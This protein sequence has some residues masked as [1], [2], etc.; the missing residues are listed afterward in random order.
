MSLLPANITNSTGYTCTFTA[1][2]TYLDL[3][4]ASS[5]YISNVASGNFEAAGTWTGGSSYPMS[6]N[7]TTISMA[8]SPTITLTSA[9]DAVNSLT[10]SGS[11]TFTLAGGSNTL[12]VWNNGLT[13]GTGQIL[14]NNATMFAGSAGFVLNGGTLGGSG[15]YSSPVTMTGGTISGATFSSAASVSILS[16]TA[17]LSGGT[18]NGGMTIGSNGGSSN[19][20][21]NVTGTVTFGSG[22]SAYPALLGGNGTINFGGTSN[23]LR[24]QS[25]KIGGNL[26]IEG[27]T[28]RTGCGCAAVRPSKSIRVKRPPVCGN[29]AGN[30]RHNYLAGNG[31]QTAGHG[32]REYIQLRHCRFE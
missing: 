25:G 3:L 29:F 28:G 17:T 9:T 7:A 8:Q 30:R 24:L 11:G 10:L 19:P 13:V 27:A 22:I 12:T 6:A 31:L 20:T 5:S 15:T 23:Y 16:G 1:T 14:I 21:V 32:G 2:P 26:T 18:F 4:V